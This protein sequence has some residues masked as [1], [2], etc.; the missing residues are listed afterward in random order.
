MDKKQIIIISIAI[1]AVVASI[2][3][4]IFQLL[5]PKRVVKIERLD[6]YSEAEATV[7]VTD[8]KQLKT[9]YKAAKED[10]INTEGVPDKLGIINNYKVSFDD[11]RYFMIQQGLNKYCFYGNPNKQ[12]EMVINMP[13]GLYDLV[14][15]LMEDQ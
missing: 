14:I 15:S 8:K 9:L 1:V 12:K 3:F 10:N 6:L 4:V 2:I 5:A 11:G 13:D 7:E